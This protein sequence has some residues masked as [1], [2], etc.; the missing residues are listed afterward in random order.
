MVHMHA[1]EL[2]SL[3]MMHEACA[4]GADTETDQLGLVRPKKISTPSLQS[5][6]LRTSCE[7]PELSAD[8][9]MCAQLCDQERKSMESLSLS[10]GVVSLGKLNFLSR[11]PE[12]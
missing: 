2:H 5:D 1:A 11:N 3:R 6:A 7:M 8:A 12:G 4:G 9:Q 10:S